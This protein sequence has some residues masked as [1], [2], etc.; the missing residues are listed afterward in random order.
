MLFSSIRSIR[1]TLPWNGGPLCLPFTLIRQAKEVI[2]HG[3]REEHHCF[4]LGLLGASAWAVWRNY[5][6]GDPVN[7]PYCSVRGLCP[8]L[9]TILPVPNTAPSQY[10]NGKG[11]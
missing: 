6:Q 9:K 11:K 7:D 8:R 3:P 5:G 2:A 1:L 4:R 10:L